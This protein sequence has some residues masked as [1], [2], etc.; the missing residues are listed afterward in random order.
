MHTTKKV[1][2][3]I[4]AR[5]NSTRLVGKMLL[6]IA[7][8]PMIQ[9]VYEQ[10]IQARYLHSVWVATDDERIKNLVQSFGGNV[11]MTSAD[12]VCGTDRVAEAVRN[13]AVDIVV[14]IQGDQPFIDPH[15]IDELTE[16]M[17]QRP[18]VN[19]ATLAKKMQKE[20]MRFPSVVKTVFDKNGRALFFSRALI[21]YPFRREKL[22]VY[23][24]I[25]LYAY[26][27]DFLQMIAALPLGNLEQV[28][29]LEQLRVL[30]NGYDIT[31]VETNCAN[32]D[33]S[34]FGVDT[35]SE[36]EKAERLLSKLPK[37]SKKA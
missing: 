37:N 19:M 22:V 16:I 29:S 34:G 8:T 2:G 10:V 6:P 24:H 23:E 13:M 15:M 9:R 21:P 17:L 11:I 7:G 12:H 33:F 32:A 3:V 18:K 36:L 4:P 31:V 35:Q 30:E 1:I 20:D 25:G 5:Y 26:Q 28:E 27:M 14:N